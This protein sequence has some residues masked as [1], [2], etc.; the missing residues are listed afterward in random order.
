M[1]QIFFPN[2]PTW[3]DK[4][5]MLLIGIKKFVGLLC[6]KFRN[7]L[8]FY[9]TFRDTILVIRVLHAA[10]DWTRFFPNPKDQSSK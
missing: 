6:Q 3:E 9:K 5:K 8:I 2:I 10:Q 4:F 7:Y 1:L